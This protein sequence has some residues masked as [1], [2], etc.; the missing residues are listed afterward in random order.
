MGLSC[1]LL[2][3][4]LDVKKENTFDLEFELAKSLTYPYIVQRR[5]K[6]LRK[7]LILF[8]TD[9]CHPLQLVKLNDVFH[10]QVINENV[11]CA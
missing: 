1:F 8:S 3:K 6:G 4:D 5:I 7:S 10:T 2:K 9:N 11:L